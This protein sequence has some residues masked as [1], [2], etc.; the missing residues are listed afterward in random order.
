[1]TLGWC[2]EVTLTRGTAGAKGVVGNGVSPATSTVGTCCFG[3]RQCILQ[4]KRGGYDVLRVCGL[5]M[6]LRLTTTDKPLQHETTT[7]KCSEIDHETNTMRGLLRA[8]YRL[9]LHSQNRF[10]FGRRP[11]F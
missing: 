11:L 8:Q 1:M 6:L 4:R 10:G 7:I 2:L 5:D 9:L 3:R